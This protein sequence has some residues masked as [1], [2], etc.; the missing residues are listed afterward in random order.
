MTQGLPFALQWNVQ[1]V[2]LFWTIV[3]YQPSYHGFQRNSQRACNIFFYILV[4]QNFRVHCAAGYKGFLDWGLFTQ[5]AD[6]NELGLG[7]SE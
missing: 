6:S 4:I 2:P 5:Q 1:V 3:P 7:Y